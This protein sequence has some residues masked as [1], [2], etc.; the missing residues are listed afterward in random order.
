MD[1]FQEFLRRLFKLRNLAPVIIIVGAIV[2]SLGLMPFGIRFTTDQIILALL[3]FLAIDTLVERLDLLANMEHRINTIQKM[4]TPKTG[5]D[6]FLRK[7]GDF[8][9][10]EQ[11]IDKA[12]SDI[13][14]AGVTLDT[15][16]TMTGAF[17]SKMRQG[18]NIRFLAL[19]PDG[20]ALQAAARYFGSDPEFTAG[21]VRGNLE[22]I[23]SRIKRTEKGSMEI[24]VLD[25]VFPTGYLITDPSSSRGQMIVQLYLYCWSA[26]TAPLFEL[27]KTDDPQWFSTYFYQFEK[28]WNDAKSFLS[29]ECEA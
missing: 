27:S 28:A 15:M 9:R 26:E 19:A 20:E 17:E 29:L 3:A 13:W 24:R 6:T 7:R 25:R 12:R 11:L 10:M 5:A 18:C 16:V 4:L 1:G 22:T 14:V 23:A 8:P 21:R 2:G